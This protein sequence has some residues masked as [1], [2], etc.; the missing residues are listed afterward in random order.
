MKM[1]KGEQYL[2]W[3]LDMMRVHVPEWEWECGVHTYN[4]ASYVSVH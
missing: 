3:A 1:Q 2:E 4:K